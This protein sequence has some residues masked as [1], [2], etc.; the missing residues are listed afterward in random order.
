[1]GMFDYVMVPCP[2]CGTTEEFQSKAGDCC[3][4]RLTLAD[5]PPAVLADI[6][7]D[8]PVECRKCGSLFEVTVQC[9]AYSTL[10]VPNAEN[11][12]D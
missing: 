1:M 2:R 3:L 5:A 9:L 11:K 4:D 10:Y 8:P 12:P 6:A 7:R